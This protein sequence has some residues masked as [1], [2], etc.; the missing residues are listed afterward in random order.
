[1]LDQNLKKNIKKFVAMAYGVPFIDGGRDLSGWD[2]AGL[3]INAFRYCLGIELPDL[4]GVSALD[5]TKAAKI[6]DQFKK[7]LD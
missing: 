2:C 4:A 7:I 6:F 5:A 1:M 3:V